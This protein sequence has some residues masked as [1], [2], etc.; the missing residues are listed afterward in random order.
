M[1]CDYHGHSRRKN[2]FMYGC[3]IPNAP[4]ESR[5]FPFILSSISP[6]FVYHYSRF[7]NQRGTKES[8][9]RMSIFNELK[10]HPCIYTME[11]SFCGNDEGPF[12]KY[13]FSTDNLMQTGVDFCRA[14]LIH[15]AIP[16][17]NSIMDGLLRNINGLYTHYKLVND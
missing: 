6:F 1:F 14:I 11:S 10:G 5:L 9:A 4:E 16:S 13:H 3:T 17:P 15:Q 8:T 7:G 2:I 12:A